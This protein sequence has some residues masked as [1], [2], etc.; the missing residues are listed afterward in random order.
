MMGWGRVDLWR[1]HAMASCVLL[2]VGV[3]AGAHTQKK[4]SAKSAEYARFVEMPCTRPW[5]VA[6]GSTREIVRCGTV[7]VPQ[8]RSAPN[9]KRLVPVVLPVVIYS[10]PGVRGTPL[11]FLAGGPG[12]SSIDAVQR[13]L[14][15]TP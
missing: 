10:L 3:T 12:E 7:T 13:V 5:G 11:V 8:D 2:C 9:D 15:E 4:S 1:A 6:P 14:L